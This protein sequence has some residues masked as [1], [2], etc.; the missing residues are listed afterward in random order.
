MVT[1]AFLTAPLTT[2]TAFAFAGVG[3]I[4]NCMLFELVTADVV[5]LLSAKAAAVLNCCMG[6]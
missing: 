4:D 2:I 1:V 3:C 5:S 6:E